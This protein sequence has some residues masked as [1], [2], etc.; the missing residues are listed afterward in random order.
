VASHDVFGT[1]LHNVKLVGGEPYVSPLMMSS[2]DAAAI[3]ADG[4]F[5]LVFIDGDHS[6]ESTCED[7]ALWKNKVRVGGILCGHDCECRPYGSLRD[8]ICAAR[9]VDHISGTGTPFAVIHP[10]VVLAVDEAFAGSANLWADELLQRPNGTCGRATLWDVVIPGG[11]RQSTIDSED[12]PILETGV[13][14]S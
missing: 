2:K 6:Y 4:C 1:F 12:F 14:R 3:V 8:G 10:G 11:T 5:D 7:I 9:R 13:N